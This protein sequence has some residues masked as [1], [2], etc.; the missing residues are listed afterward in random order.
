MAEQLS[1]MEMAI[2]DAVR[3]GMVDRADI[4]KHA[5]TLISDYDAAGPMLWTE[6]TVRQFADALDSLVEKGYLTWQTYLLIAKTTEKGKQF[7]ADNATQMEA[8]PKVD[9]SAKWFAKQNKKMV[10]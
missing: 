7:I 2:M 5:R 10:R 4:G 9:D 8:L 1:P 3:R 6:P